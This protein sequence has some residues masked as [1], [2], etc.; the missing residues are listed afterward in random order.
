MS[1]GPGARKSGTSN[2][3]RAP[4]E[5]RDA[6]LEQQPLDELG[7]GLVARPGGADERAFGVGRL[8]LAGALGELGARRLLRRAL[9]H[10]RQPA[11]AAEALVRGS[12]AA[13][14]E[15]HTSASLNP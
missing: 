13:A 15:G 14:H 10:E 2:P 5:R 9:A 3:P 11:V 12:C 7:L 4:G 8:D 6:L 1:R